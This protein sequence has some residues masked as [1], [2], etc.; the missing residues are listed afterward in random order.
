VSRTPRRKKLPQCGLCRHFGHT[1]L[2]CRLRKPRRICRVCQD[3]P[4]RRE[5]PACSGC[6][7]PYAEDPPA[8]LVTRREDQRTYPIA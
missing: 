4:H 2:E 8:E 6:G 3:L 5:Q 7:R 1:V